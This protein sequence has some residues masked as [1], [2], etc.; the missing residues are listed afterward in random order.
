M[1][2]K[3]RIAVLQPTQATGRGTLNLGVAADH[4]LLEDDGRTTN[5]AD[6]SQPVARRTL[7]MTIGEPETGEPDQDIAGLA[8]TVVRGR[9]ILS[10]ASEG[11]ADVAGKRPVTP[12]TRFQISSVSKPWLTTVIGLLHERGA[13]EWDDR[14]DRWLPALPWAQEITVHQLLTHTA[15]LGHWEAVGGHEQFAALADER[16]I[17][18]LAGTPLRS[19]PGTAWSYSGLGY[20]LLGRIASAIE[21]QPYPSIVDREIIDRLGLTATTCGRPLDPRAD[22]ALGDHGR[23][24]R[25]L[26]ALASL[27]GTGDIWSTANDVAE[28]ATAFRKGGLV[29]PVTVRTLLESSV[30][31][32]EAAYA[33]HGVTAQRYAYGRYLGTL[34]G[35]AAWFHSGDNPGFQSFLGHI[36]DSG[37]TI[38]VLCNSDH[39]PITRLVRATLRAAG[40]TT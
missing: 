25:P 21:D 38:A 34:G 12:R 30:D 19:R 31:L 40:V 6:N 14:I 33:R 18:L 1:R 32:G 5:P 39:A 16:R 23:D 3:C 24:S 28:F 9:E 15:G 8:V 13:L 7:A 2:V 37:T 26:L 29:A 17:E 22:V 36:L 4:Q 27:P 11:T 35:R 10:S 20:V